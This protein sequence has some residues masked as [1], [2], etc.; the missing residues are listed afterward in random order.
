M[1]S[2]PDGRNTR[3][4]AI[5]KTDNQGGDGLIA[6]HQVAAITTK[7]AAMTAGTQTRPFAAGNQLRQIP[8]DQNRVAPIMAAVDG[9]PASSAAIET[10]VSLAGELRA[11][12][13]FVYVR[14]GPAG[15]LGAPVYQRRLTSSM[16]RGR[17]VLRGALEAAAAAAVDAEGEI[18][19]GSPRR[20]IADFARDRGARLVVLGSRR[21]KVGRSVSRGVARAAEQPVVITQ[22]LHRLAEAGKA[23]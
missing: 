6:L 16:A 2:R 13:V 1:S 12:V 9:S 21:R 17:R 22:G 15:V 11:P 8:Q 23:A 7:E 20:R 10:A 5:W 18:L 19:E 4:T 3:A 14:R